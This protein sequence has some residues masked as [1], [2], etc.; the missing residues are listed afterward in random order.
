MP[1]KETSEKDVEAK[2]AA[3][4]KASEEKAAKEKAEAEKKEAEAKE[5]KKKDLG[6]GGFLKEMGDKIKKAKTVEDLEALDEEVYNIWQQSIP[7][8]IQ[9]LAQTRFLEIQESDGPKKD[10]VESQSSDPEGWKKVSTEEMKKAEEDRKLV[11]YNPKT[12]FALIKE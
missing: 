9:A 10:F 5:A 1:A 11:G 12:G 3:E 8:S 7:A 6:S 2:K 4:K